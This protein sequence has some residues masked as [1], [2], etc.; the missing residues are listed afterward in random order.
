M[1]LTVIFGVG[2]FSSSNMWLSIIFASFSAFFGTMTIVSRVSL[3]LELTPGYRST[4]MSLNV[5]ANSIGMVIG[6]S[7]GGVVLLTYS[8]QYLGMIGLAIGILAA[9][10]F[11][12]IVTDPTTE[13]IIPPSPQ[14]S[15]SSPAKN[16]PI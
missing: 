10:T 15:G 8:Y 1:I 2:H 4:M 12:L 16:S 6:P 11:H 7:I 5:A 9:L 13:E 14:R 3:A